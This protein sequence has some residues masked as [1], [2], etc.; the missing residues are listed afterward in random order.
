M[1]FPSE[2]TL[3][4]F[5]P[6]GVGGAHQAPPF[7]VV[8]SE[9]LNVD[10]MKNKIRPQKRP[11]DDGSPSGAGSASGVKRALRIFLQ[12]W[13]ASRLRYL[14]RGGLLG[15]L[16]FPA[17]PFLASPQDPTN[18]QRFA[19]TDSQVFLSPALLGGGVAF[20]TGILDWKGQGGHDRV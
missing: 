19:D 15:H 11:R 17:S 7:Y 9:F 13:D 2:N 12:E 10:C 5:S 16:R 8:A 18:R 3:A 6:R 14:S 4:S 1:Y 20:R